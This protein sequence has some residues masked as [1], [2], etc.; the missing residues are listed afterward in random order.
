[1]TLDHKDCLSMKAFAAANIVF[2]AVLYIIQ[3][4]EFSL[5]YFGLSLFLSTLYFFFMIVPAIL[6]S[7]FINP[8]TSH[9]LLALISVIAILPQVFGFFSSPDIFYYATSDTV[10]IAGEKYTTDG[11]LN[12]AAKLTGHLIAGICM[13]YTYLYFIKRKLK[14][15]VNKKD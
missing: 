4:N 8:L 12:L 5:Y 2:A 13:S 7:A 1:M 6:A 15:A 10:L 3:L 9:K 11:Y 14:K